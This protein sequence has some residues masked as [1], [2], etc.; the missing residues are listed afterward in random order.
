MPQ[1]Q[2]PWVTQH[3]GEQPAQRDVAL[4]DHLGPDRRP[5]R[6]RQQFGGHLDHHRLP[7]AEAR[8][9]AGDVEAHRAERRLHVAPAPSVV[10]PHRQLPATLQHARADG[11]HGVAE[12]VAGRAVGGLR[13]RQRGRWRHGPGSG[14]DPE[15]QIE[16]GLHAG[17]RGVG[18][19]R[20]GGRFVAALEQ[21]P[22]RRG[23]LD[24]RWYAELGQ[25][26]AP[27]RHRQRPELAGR[28]GLGGSGT[29]EAERD[30]GCRHRAEQ[31][32]RARQT[33]AG[34]CHAD[35]TGAYTLWIRG[36]TR[37]RRRQALATRWPADGDPRRRAYSARSATIG[38][39]FVARRAGR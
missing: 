35:S 13:Q 1:Q 34:R 11:F 23:P 24:P 16:S 30:R 6:Q 17:D 7:G 28:V 10:E 19:P 38:S 12:A 26:P 39:T 31:P 18:S 4:E 9:H 25:R 8:R 33:T 3:L 20:R 5:E 37:Q 14:L 32:S 21:D 22:Q 27:A 36:T 2:R 15:R 29:P